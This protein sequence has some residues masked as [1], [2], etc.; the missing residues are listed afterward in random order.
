MVS[1]SASLKYRVNGEDIVVRGAR[2]LAC[3][4]CREIVLRFNDAKALGQRALEI[5]RA[6]YGLL[7]EEEIRRMRERLGMTQG[8]LAALLRLGKNTISR[9]E[10]G[11]NVQTASLD[12]LLRCV[13]D[14]PGSLEY[15]RKRAA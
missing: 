11:R 6:K 7:S 2:H 8:E 3:S 14:V 13:R 9:W 4:K 12:L 1:T 15:L 5:Y 10:S